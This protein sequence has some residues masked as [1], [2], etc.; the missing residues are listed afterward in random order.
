M[1]IIAKLLSSL[2]IK[3]QNLTQF[4]IKYYLYVKIYY[5]FNR[6]L[7]LIFNLILAILY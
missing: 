3:S 4:N 6:Y 5:N 2:T 1:L 7:Y